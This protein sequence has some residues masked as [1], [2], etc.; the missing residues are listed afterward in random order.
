MAQIVIDGVLFSPVLAHSL[1]PGDLFT[2]DAED[3]PWRVFYIERESRDVLW[4]GVT[5]AGTSGSEFGH[6]V[7]L[8][9]SVLRAV[10]ARA[11]RGGAR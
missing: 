2:L 4:I 1:E 10:G 9:Q 7:M 8:N 5:A 11:A 3:A 6:N